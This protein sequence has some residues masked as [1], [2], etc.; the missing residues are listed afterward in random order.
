MSGW[1]VVAAL[2]FGA[3]FVGVIF[4]LIAGT[5]WAVGGLLGALVVFGG[6]WL[7]LNRVGRR[8]SRAAGGY[9]PR[10]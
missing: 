1:L 7:L 8:Q 4:L 5:V 3:L 10:T 6:L 2:S 9:G